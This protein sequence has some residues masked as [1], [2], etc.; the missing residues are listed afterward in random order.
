MLFESLREKQ[1]VSVKEA[2][3]REGLT[4]DAT[5]FS[6]I[7]GGVSQPLLYRF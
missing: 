4:K 3:T 6:C 1:V 2:F 7:Q 5:V